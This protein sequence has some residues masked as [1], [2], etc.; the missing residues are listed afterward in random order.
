[1]TD[2]DPRPTGSTPETG[3]IR[4]GD[5]ERNGAVTALGEHM[6]TGRLDLDEYGTRSALANNARTVADVQVLFAD[7]PAP[8]PLLPGIRPGS[9]ALAARPDVMAPA[10]RG[11]DAPAVVDERSKAQKLVAATAAASTV[12]ALVLFF[13]T[14]LWWWFLLIPAISS[15]AG[16]VW[17]DSWKNPDR[18]R[19]H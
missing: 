10:S 19:S 13:T 17:G 4:I 15:I 18:R 6:A 9:S 11:G 14:G 8:H 2:S 12:I 1:M 7:L 3:S 16:S 5:V